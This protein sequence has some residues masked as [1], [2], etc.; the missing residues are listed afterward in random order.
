MRFWAVGMAPCSITTSNTTGSADI[1]PL[2]INPFTMAMDASGIS[3]SRTAATTARARASAR[4]SPSRSTCRTLRSK[5]PLGLGFGIMA[6]SI[7]LTVGR[8][9]LLMGSWES[10]ILMLWR[11]VLAGALPLL[12][13]LPALL[14]LPFGGNMDAPSTIADAASV[15]SPRVPMRSMAA[16]SMPTRVAVSQLHPAGMAVP[17]L[18]AAA[19]GN[20][21]PPSGVKPTASPMNTPTSGRFMIPRTPRT[22][23]MTAR[24]TAPTQYRST[25]LRPTRCRW[26]RK[27]AGSSLTR[28]GKLSGACP[29]GCTSL[30]GCS[31]R[32]A[33]AHSK[34]DQAIWYSARYPTARAFTAGASRLAMNTRGSV[35]LLPNMQHAL[36]IS[37]VPSGRGGSGAYSAGAASGIPAAA[38]VAAAMLLVSADG[39]SGCQPRILM[40]RL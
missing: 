22:K 34:G 4:P 35:M 21:R 2:A 39:F 37:S 29:P 20:R 27:A 8:P 14:P 10:I 30:E 1:H 18:P 31:T 23:A 38:E 7:D 28:C 13:L 36:T 11:P 24:R 3:S 26:L 16:L 9:E 15:A 33:S 17:G 5:L 6:S 40:R 12:L 32:G 19:G 25:P